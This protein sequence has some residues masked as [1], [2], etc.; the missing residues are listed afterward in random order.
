MAKLCSGLR[1]HTRN[2][3]VVRRLTPELLS[4]IAANYG[5]SDVQRFEPAAVELIDDP[6]LAEFS[7]RHDDVG[8]PTRW[9]WCCATS[10]ASHARS[11]AEARTRRSC[12]GAWG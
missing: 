5:A 7:N 11:A 2:G 4:A 12:R 8:G 1:A 9:R 3:L 6:F 10:G